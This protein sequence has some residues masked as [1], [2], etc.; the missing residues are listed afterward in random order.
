M[1]FYVH[2]GKTGGTEIKG[3]IRA[4]FG[5][6]KTKEPQVVDQKIV[7]LNHISLDDA[8]QKFG[9]PTGIAFAYR[10]PTERFV[11]G[12]YCR[13][14]MG[15]PDHQA[16]WDAREAAAFAHFETANALAEALD[17]KDLKQRAAAHY[18]MDAIRHLRRGY[19]FHFGDLIDFALD[20]ASQVLACIDTVNIDSKGADFLQRIGVETP[21][22]EAF[23]EPRSKITYP[24][25]LSAIA[26]R[27]L[28]SFWAAE[29]E[30]YD[31]F[32]EL[33]AQVL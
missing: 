4:H 24:R 7:L 26:T 2:I 28:R 17:G 9:V 21:K 31:A 27:N 11:S 12:F 3:A 23:S 13:Q 32:K 5:V 19:V 25:E 33:E 8:I 22:I 1:I 20:Q 30:F 15:W 29:Y 18:A 16:R 10:D 14:R 6:Q